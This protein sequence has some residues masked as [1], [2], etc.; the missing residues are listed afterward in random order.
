MNKTDE[1]EISL[2]LTCSTVFVH[3]DSENSVFIDFKLEP[4]PLVIIDG[5]STRNGLKIVKDY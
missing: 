2:L 5:F 1:V 3:D 4:M